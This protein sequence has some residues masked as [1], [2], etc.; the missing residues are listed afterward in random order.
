MAPAS[1]L[2]WAIPDN[3]DEEAITRFVE[4]LASLDRRARPRANGFDERLRPW[5]AEADGARPNVE[6]ALQCLGWCRAL[7]QLAAHLTSELWWE[8]LELL[9]QTAGESAALRLEDDPLAHQLFAGELPLTLA[10]LFPEI[11]LCDALA[12]DS[13]RALSRGPLDLLNGEGL[14]NGADLPVAAPAAFLLDPLPGDR[15]KARQRLLEQSRV[16][17]IPVA[18]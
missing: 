7:P 1:P 6:H 2:G 10:Y 13:R 8:L 9:I 15:Q 4:H 5:L 17:A 12:T 3:V 16:V 14:P 11:K 18:C